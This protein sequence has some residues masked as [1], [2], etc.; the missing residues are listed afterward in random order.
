MK[1]PEFN[2]FIF[3]DSNRVS[4]EPVGPQPFLETGLTVRSPFKNE[5]R[6]IGILRQLLL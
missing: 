6:E 2:I 1:K 3:E 5:F 4:L